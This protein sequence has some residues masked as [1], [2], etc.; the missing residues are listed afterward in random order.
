MKIG[1]VYNL[2]LRKNKENSAEFFVYIYIYIILKLLMI[3]QY[4]NEIS[5]EEIEVIIIFFIFP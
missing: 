1:W 5:Y 4:I 2:V 3:I